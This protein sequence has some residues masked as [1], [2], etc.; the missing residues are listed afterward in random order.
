DGPQRARF[1]PSVADPGSHDNGPIPVRNQTSGRQSGDDDEWPALC[2]RG[3]PSESERI[4]VPCPYAYQDEYWKFPQVVWSIRA[5]HESRG[6]LLNDVAV[7]RL[8]EPLQIVPG[9][10]EPVTLNSQPT[11]PPESLQCTLTGWGR[12][13][14]GPGSV[15]SNTPL[16]VNLGVMSNQQCSQFY[17]RT[18]GI[19]N[20]CAGGVQGKGGC[21]GDSG[22][23]LMCQCGSGPRV[24]AGIVS[25]GVRGCL[26][27]YPTVFA[28][29]STY[30]SWIQQVTQGQGQGVEGEVEPAEMSV[31]LPL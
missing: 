4:S 28:R 24:Q 10:V 14:E 30:I 23:P 29:V 7:L 1:M 26:T 15:S 20:V 18:I 13:T 6:Q 12:T 22:G 31:L 5:G 25:F 19:E 27:V 17:T 2:H 16:K 8:R 21:N 11:C 3:D 9:I